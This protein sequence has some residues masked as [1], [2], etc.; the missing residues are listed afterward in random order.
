MAGAQLPPV[1]EVR[2][3][4]TIK[5]PLL[6][7]LRHDLTGMFR[8]GRNDLTWGGARSYCSGRGMRMVSLDSAAK[9]DHF[10]QQV[11]TLTIYLYLHLLTLLSISSINLYLWPGRG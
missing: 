2:I 10:M 11:A 7:L 8:E 1:L 4:D 6:Q 5:T 3:I 9:R